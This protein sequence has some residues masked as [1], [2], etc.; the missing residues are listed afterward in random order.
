MQW[1][2]G[3]SPHVFEPFSKWF[4]LVMTG[5]VPTPIAP[6]SLTADELSTLEAP[7]LS[8]IGTKDAVVGDAQAAAKLASNIPGSKVRL[9]DTGHLIGVELS[10]QVNTEIMAFLALNETE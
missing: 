5:M 4:R 10:D 6:R 2:F 1:A 9:V 3:D 7:T 8:F